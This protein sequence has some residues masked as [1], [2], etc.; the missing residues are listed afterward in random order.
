MH[1]WCVGRSFTYTSIS[2]GGC[3]R[4]NNNA[5][6]ARR[7]KWHIHASRVVRLPPII[8]AFFLLAA[9]EPSPGTVPTEPVHPSNDPSTLEA[10]SNEAP[11]FDHTCNLGMEIIRRVWWAMDD[12]DI[13]SIF[14]YT[15]SFPWQRQTCTSKYFGSSCRSIGRSQPVQLFSYPPAQLPWRSRMALI[16][17]A[18][19]TGLQVI[20]GVSKIG[21]W[22]HVGLNVAT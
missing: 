18:N 9:A 4:T 14:T 21:P 11:L 6:A 2:A 17:C 19:S 13:S 7:H 8:H 20:W 16:S 5:A 12:D 1:G 10:R 3:I 22:C 15:Q